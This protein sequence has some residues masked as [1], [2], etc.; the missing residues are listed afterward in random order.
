MGLFRMPALKE[1]VEG[2]DNGGGSSV[3]DSVQKIKDMFEQAT[4]DR[5]E[6]NKAEMEGS[7]DKYGAEAAKPR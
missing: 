4:K 7:T 1:D 5:L 3:D 6:I 2:A